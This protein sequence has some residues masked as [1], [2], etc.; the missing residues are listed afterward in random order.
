LLLLL[1][2][3]VIALAVVGVVIVLVSQVPPMAAT[4]THRGVMIGR[5]ALVLVGLAALS[6]FAAAVVDILGRS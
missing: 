6:G 5:V 4:R 3:L 1:P 2:P